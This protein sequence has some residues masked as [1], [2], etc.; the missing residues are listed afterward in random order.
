MNDYQKKAREF[1]VVDG[2]E[3]THL[4]YLALGLCEE[5]GEVAGKVKRIIR[6]D[7]G[8][9]TEERLMQII[10]ELGDTLWYLATLADVLEVPLDTVAWNN[11]RKL[12]DRR[13]RG[14]INGS[15]DNR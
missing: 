3:M 13:N 5:A 9:L 10:L 4:H 8:E 14:A 12:T 2:D 7:G 1:F 15:G 11:I 6:D